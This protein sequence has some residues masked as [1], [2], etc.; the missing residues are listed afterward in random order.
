[1]EGE[2]GGAGAPA[3]RRAGGAVAGRAARKGGAGGGAAPGA[4][5]RPPP[6]PP[7]AATAAPVP[8]DEPPVKRLRSQGLRGGG[9]GRSKDGPPSANSCVASLPTMTAPASRSFAT[10]TASACGT[11]SCMTLECPVVATPAVSY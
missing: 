9:H 5:R 11:W 1:G 6:T 8:L 10:A 4:P 2:G 7:P 3:R